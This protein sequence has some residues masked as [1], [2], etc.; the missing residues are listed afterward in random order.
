VKMSKPRGGCK[1]KRTRQTQRSKEGVEKTQR[2]DTSKLKGGKTEQGRRVL[3][4]GKSAWIRKEKRNKNLQKGIEGT[5]E[6]KKGGA[7]S[8]IN[9]CKMKKETHNEDRTFRENSKKDETKASGHWG[10]QGNRKRE[11]VQTKL[12]PALVEKMW[13]TT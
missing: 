11:N 13:D 4:Q 3:L 5:G 6:K 1:R 9:I 12:D 8:P 10:A 7:P 2:M